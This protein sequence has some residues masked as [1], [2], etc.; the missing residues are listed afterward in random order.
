MDDWDEADE[1]MQ[2]SVFFSTHLDFG[3]ALPPL[4]FRLLSS[5]F[6]PPLEVRPHCSL[7]VWGALPS[8]F[9]Q[10]PAARLIL[11]HFRHKFAAF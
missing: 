10:S 2:R 8:G 6:R 11:V 9:R 3:E 7:G 1:L 5:S 4:P